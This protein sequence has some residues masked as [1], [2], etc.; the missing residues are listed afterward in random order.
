LATLG[1][2]SSDPLVAPSDPFY[3][4]LNKGPTTQLMAAIESLGF[5]PSAVQY[6]SIPEPSAFVLAAL[7]LAAASRRMRS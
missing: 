5:A 2:F 1:W 3:M 6:L 7:G 4:I